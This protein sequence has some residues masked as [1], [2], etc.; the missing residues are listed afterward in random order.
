MKYIIVTS[1]GSTH[2]LVLKVT[3]KIQDGFTPI[4]GA[5]SDGYRYF[6][7]MIKS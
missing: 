2:D 7:A 6:Q 1:E 5:Q 4:G 3:E